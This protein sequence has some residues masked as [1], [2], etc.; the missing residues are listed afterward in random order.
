MARKGKPPKSESEIQEDLIRAYGWRC[1]LLPGQEL[2][3]AKQHVQVLCHVCGRQ[4]RQTPESIKKKRRTR[5]ACNTTKQ[6]RRLVPEWE[7]EEY[8]PWPPGEYID[9]DGI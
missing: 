1:Q 8:P 2:W 4:F 6:Y 9:G 3:G 5:C 7:E